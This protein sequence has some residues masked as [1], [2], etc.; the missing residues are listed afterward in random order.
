MTEF[1][2]ATQSNGMGSRQ[3][4]K[5]RRFWSLVAFTQSQNKADRASSL[6]FIIN[7]V[8]A[9]LLTFDAFKA[10]Q[11]G[12]NGSA[13]RNKKESKFVQGGFLGAFKA[14]VRA[15]H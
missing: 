11:C 14:T 2:R 5:Q 10:A 15:Q 4:I 1:D 3:K 9:F 7:S 8:Q 13:D 6:K 12:G